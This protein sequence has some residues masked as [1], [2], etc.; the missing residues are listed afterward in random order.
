MKIKKLKD[1][2]YGYICIPTDIMNSIIDSAPFQRL[3]RISQTSYAPLYAS[4]VHNRFVHSLSVYHLGR[5]VGNVLVKEIKEKLKGY[6]DDHSAVNA[7]LQQPN[8]G[9][10]VWEFQI[11]CLAKRS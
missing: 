5:K 4:A 7:G 11:N 6:F 3:R 10:Y 9:K 1:P 8:I 2:L